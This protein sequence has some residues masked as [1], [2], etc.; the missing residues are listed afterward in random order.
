M[1]SYQENFTRTT[2]KVT[3][4][5]SDFEETE[6]TPEPDLSDMLELSYQKFKMTMVNVLMALQ[7]KMGSMRKNVGNISRELGILRKNQNSSRDKYMVTEMMNAFDGL[8]NRL[9]TAEERF[10]EL[11]DLSMETSKSEKLRERRLKRT[12]YNI[13][14]LL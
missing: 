10:S 5:H 4:T 2:K 8:F 1:G 12:E 9:D 6:Q 3:K 7:N 14:G 13:Q 11:E